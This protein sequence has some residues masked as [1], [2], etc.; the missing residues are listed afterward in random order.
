[1]VGNDKR[2][3]ILLKPMIIRD[4]SMVNFDASCRTKDE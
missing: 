3:S 1:M 2:D 4:K